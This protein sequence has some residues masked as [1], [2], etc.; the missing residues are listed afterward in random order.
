MLIAILASIFVFI[1]VF[2]LAN[3][4]YPS[5]EKQTIFLHK[6]K[7]D[8]MSPKLDQMFLDIAPEKLVFLD[9][10]APVL[11]AIL[12]YMLVE[13]PIGAIIG[14]ALG[15]AFPVVFI[16]ILEK[17]RRK[18]FAA[19]LVDAIMILCS[20]LRVGMSLQQAFEVLVEEIAPPM[21]QEF[22][23]VL[24]QMRMG[25]SLEAA[26]S[27]LKKRMKIEDLEMVITSLMIAKETGGDITE[28]LTKVVNTISERNKLLGKVKALTIQGKL[29]GGIMSVIPIFF[30][31]FI[32][33]SDKHYFDVFFQDS[34]G[35]GLMIYA[36]VSEVIGAYLIMKL[37]KVDV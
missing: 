37:S 33:Q 23:L 2:Y 4:F 7:I 27:D 26:L 14:G 5:V 13:K 16:K 29:Q 10:A 28:T 31:F 3:A 12:G 19:Q 34:F 1:C 35:K 21:S 18:K 24:R 15:L 22:N 17:K 8:K 30:A 25:F 9:I 6:K 36:A 32:Y 11:G 20:S